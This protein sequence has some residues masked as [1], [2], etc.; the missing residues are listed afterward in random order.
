MFNY[1]NSAILPILLFAAG[2]DNRGFYRKILEEMQEEK[3]SLIVSI[4]TDGV[5]HALHTLNRAHWRSN[6]YTRTVEQLVLSPQAV[7]WIYF[8]V[9]YGSIFMLIEIS[10]CNINS[11]GW[12]V[13]T[14]SV[15]PVFNN[16]TLWLNDSC[17]WWQTEF[18]NRAA[19]IIRCSCMSARI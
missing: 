6:F 4:F 2:S 13:S 12:A 17:H 11:L 1:T 10:N 16:G 9:S 14:R 19:R 15:V 3:V 7:I 18:I 5:R 8:T